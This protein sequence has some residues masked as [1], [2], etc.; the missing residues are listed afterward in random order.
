MK[1]APLITV[2]MAT[3][4]RSNV[5]PYSIGSVLAQS[6]SD[7]ELLVIGDGCTDD[8]QEVVEAMGDRRVRWVGL[9]NNS[10]HQSVPHNAGLA[11][12]RGQ[13]IAYL[14][15]DDLWLPDHLAIC[16]DA[17]EKRCDLAYGLSLIVSENPRGNYLAPIP[18][19]YE[20][21]RWISPSSVVHR[22]SVTD[23]VGTWKHYRDTRSVPE[24]ELWQRMFRS[25][26]RMSLLPRLSVVKI[27]A[28]ARKDVY[29]HRSTEEQALWQMR[30]QTEPGFEASEIA[31]C[32]VNLRS[33]SP[34]QIGSAPYKRVMRHSCMKPSS[35]SANDCAGRYGSD[36]PL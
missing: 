19:P 7:F 16:V 32:Y 3:Y 35:E 18:L 6:R 8:S 33:L 26:Y 28:A 21:G 34:G 12:A 14:G 13:Y 4:N 23:A 9:S 22:K 11:E 25:G 15:H 5:L 36:S 1:S 29:Q 17:I 30:I 31:M 10:G 2:I 20:S 24:A 27:P